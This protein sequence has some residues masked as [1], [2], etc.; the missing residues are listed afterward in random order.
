MALGDGT[1][2]SRIAAGLRRT[3]GKSA[4]DTVAS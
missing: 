4:G 3:V 2:K 1:R